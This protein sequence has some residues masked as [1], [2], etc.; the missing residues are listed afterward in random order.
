VQ[1]LPDVEL[2]QP[3]GRGGSTGCRSDRDLHHRRFGER[4]LVRIEAAM[5]PANDFD[6]RDDGLEQLGPVRALRL[7]ERQCRYDRCNAGV[8]S[9]QVV[10]L[11]DIA[12]VGVDTSGRLDR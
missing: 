3:G 1:G 11:E 4:F 10:E 8:A 2:E 9:D 6:P 5:H 7:C 12:H